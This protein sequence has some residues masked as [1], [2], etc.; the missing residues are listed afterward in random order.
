MKLPDLQS[1]LSGRSVK[2]CFE[3]IEILAEGEGAGE[4]EAEEET[5]RPSAVARETPP[6]SET[7]RL[8]ETSAL[9]QP[10]RV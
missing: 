10:S 6:K 5:E 7:G 2:I 8:E 1:Q 9:R 4:G 3:D